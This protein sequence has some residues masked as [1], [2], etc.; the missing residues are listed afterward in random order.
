MITPLTLL[1]RGDA[2]FPEFPDSTVIGTAPGG[3]HES[4]A[5]LRAG[6]SG[7][8]GCC[9]PGAVAPE[10]HDLNMQ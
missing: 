6:S 3:G 5:I 2:S 9:D 10:N 7:H 8:T 1:R 4:E